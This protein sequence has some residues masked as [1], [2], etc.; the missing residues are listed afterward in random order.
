MT[1]PRR[2][3]VLLLACAATFALSVALPASAAAQ[4]DA[5]EPR[6]FCYVGRPLPSCEMM[7]AAQFSYYPRIQRFSDLEAPYEWELGVLVN[8]GPGHA[9]GGTLVVGRDGNGGRTAVK[10][11]YR[12][13]MGRHAALDASGGVALAR[14]DWAPTVTTRTAVGVTGDVAVGLTD[15][16]SVGV[17]GDLLWSDLNREPVGATYGTVRF[18]TVP[19][20]VASVLGAVLA[21][22]AVGVS[23]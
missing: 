20:L 8:R 2:T 11:R 13:W 10:A 12:R 18:G 19:G 1:P 3:A 6:R 23:G 5:E 4:E 17:R 21:V 7:L 14:R 15:W 22:V 9:V 16:V